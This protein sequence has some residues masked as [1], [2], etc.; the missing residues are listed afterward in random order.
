MNAFLPAVMSLLTY[1]NVELRVGIMSCMRRILPALCRAMH[2]S[3]NHNE[4]LYESELTSVLRVYTDQMTQILSDAPPIPQFGLRLLVE[5]LT[6]SASI[7]TAVAVRVTQSGAADALISMLG[8]NESSSIRVLNDARSSGESGY[9]EAFD[10]QV[11]LTLRIIFRVKSKIRIHEQ[12]LTLPEYLLRIGLAGKL[13]EALQRCVTSTSSSPDANLHSGLSEVLNLLSDCLEYGIANQS[14]DLLKPLEDANR[15]LFAMLHI[16]NRLKYRLSP[17]A[18][19]PVL[20][21]QLLCCSCLSSHFKVFTES[22][23]K[24]LIQSK[25]DV[26]N[27]DQSPTSAIRDVFADLSV[28]PLDL[29]NV[30]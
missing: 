24:V 20:Q 9:N 21:L 19:E 11:P 3:A 8:G 7:E 23:L 16:C 5:I 27:V 22:G 28:N 15:L 26:A 29:E 17:D 13:S 18:R 12:S 4:M 14:N 2:T 6:A 30:T 10:P 1:P 25:V